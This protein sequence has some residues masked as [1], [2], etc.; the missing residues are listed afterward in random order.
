MKVS[1]QP[2]TAV[3]EHMAVKNIKAKALGTPKRRPT[4]GRRKVQQ[5]VTGTDGP[6]TQSAA[7]A[8]QPKQP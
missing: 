3:T 4:I 8:N 7:Y 6:D 5:M 2:Q 1:N